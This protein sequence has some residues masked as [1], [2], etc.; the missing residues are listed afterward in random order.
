MAFKDF[1]NQGEGELKKV[2]AEKR[3]ALRDVRFKASNKQLKNVRSIRALRADV[4]HILTRLHQ[5]TSRHHE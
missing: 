4:A 3:E 1:L 2:L 5:L